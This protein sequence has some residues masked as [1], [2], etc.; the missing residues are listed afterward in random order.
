MLIECDTC[1]A[2]SSLR[3]WNSPSRSRGIRWFEGLSTVS[4]MTKDGDAIAG[5]DAWLAFPDRP[6][7][8]AEW[9]R[10]VGDRWSLDLVRR[11]GVTLARDRRRYYSRRITVG[12]QVFA[13]R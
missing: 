4:L 6:G 12:E 7:T 2:R 10:T 13:E 8:H 11:D 1:R 3:A 9:R 5:R